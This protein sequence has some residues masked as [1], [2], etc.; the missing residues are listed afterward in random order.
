MSVMDIFHTSLYRIPVVCVETQCGLPCIVSANVTQEI[1]LTDRVEFIENEMISQ[2]CDEIEQLASQLPDRSQ[3]MP[4][5][6]YDIRKQ[7]RRLEE[8]YLSYGMGTDTDVHL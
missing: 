7:A 6:A 8:I 3:C 4:M 2:W 5:E 1:A